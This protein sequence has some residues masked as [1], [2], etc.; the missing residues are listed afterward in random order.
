MRK[1]TRLSR[2]CGWSVR[3]ATGIFALAFC[4]SAFADPSKN[5]VAL[6][7]QPLPAKAT[8]KICY[9]VTGGSRI[10]QRCDRLSAIPTTAHAMDIYGHR[11]GSY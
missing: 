2:V 4:A 11:P 10:P 3:T 7:S 5:V 8:K 1:G 6:P 9:V